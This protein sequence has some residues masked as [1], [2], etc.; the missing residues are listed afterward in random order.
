MNSIESDERA[1]TR[2][3]ALRVR[4]GAEKTVSI[5]ARHKGFEEFS[6]MRRCERQWSDRQKVTDVPLF[7]GYVFCRLDPKDRLPLLIISSVQGLVGFGNVPAPIDD[8]ELDAIRSVVKSGASAEP[9]PYLEIGQR[10]R[11]E[12]GPL[13]DLE[14]LLIDVRKRQR[15][16]ISINILKRSIAVEI[17]RGWIRPIGMPREASSGRPGAVRVLPN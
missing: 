17:D 1:Q 3:Y 16:V 12:H 13:R 10:V 9:W 5:I 7:A 15:I 4:C 6:P 14:G 8:H 2:W 11:L